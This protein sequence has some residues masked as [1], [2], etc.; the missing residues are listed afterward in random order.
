MGKIIEETSITYRQPVLPSGG[1][2][3]TQKT[4]ICQEEKLLNMRRITNHCTLSEE[5]IFATDASVFRT[6][7]LLVVVT[8]CPSSLASLLQKF[9]FH[10]PYLSI[11]AHYARVSRIKE[12]FLPLTHKSEQSCSLTHD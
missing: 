1:I 5:A 12:H 2:A 4:F 10:T 11:L 3:E 9:P 8:S 7:G 6:S